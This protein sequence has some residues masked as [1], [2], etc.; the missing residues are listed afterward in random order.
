MATAFSGML[1]GAAGADQEFASA[2]QG[3]VNVAVSKLPEFLSMGV[4]ILSSL[5]SGIV[6]SIPTLVAAVPQIVAEIGEALTELLPQVL[7]MGVQL[8]VSL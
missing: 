8:L 6:Q 2:V 5:A 4:Q 1:S 7:N 3:L